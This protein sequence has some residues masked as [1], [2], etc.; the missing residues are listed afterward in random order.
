M[1]KTLLVIIIFV[2]FAILTAFAFTIF[3]TPQEVVRYQDCILLQNTKTKQVDCF[4]CANNICKDAQTD[5][6]PYVAPE[7]GIPYSCFKT[8]KGC[9][10]AQ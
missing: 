8:D 2:I 5:W 6:L 3:L 10:L 7:V 1:S 4:G 9:Q